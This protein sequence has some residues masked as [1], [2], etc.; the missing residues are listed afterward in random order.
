MFNPFTFFRRRKP[1][2]VVITQADLERFREWLNDPANKEEIE[3]QLVSDEERER[4]FAE[5]A[6]L[7]PTREMLERRCLLAA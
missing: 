5:I 6:K 3:K 4:I 2:K 1:E 7:K